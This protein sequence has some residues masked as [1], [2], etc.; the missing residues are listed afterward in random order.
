MTRPLY[1]FQGYARTPMVAP[2]PLG[3]TIESMA[4]DTTMR[5]WR[6]QRFG[7]R[8]VRH[9][10]DPLVEPL[11]SGIRVLAHAGPDGAEFLDAD[12]E[13]QSWPEI[14]ARLATVLQAERAVLDGYLTLESHDPGVG[15][16]PVPDLHPR[17]RDI[18]RRLFWVGDDR[19][20]RE[21]EAL[22]ETERPRPV[23][24]GEKAVFVAVDLLALDGEQLL[25]VPLLERKRL[26]DAVVGDDPLIRRGVHVRPPIGTWLATWKSLGF[27]AIAYKGANS[28]YRPGAPN[29]DWATAPILIR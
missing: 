3:C 26:L 4:V 23:E 14:A 13:T 25:D 29:D 10:D 12:G 18:G 27:R 2:A 8:N 11:W 5:A 19:R 28:R 22:R 9:I 6:P 7:R 20:Q 24:P 15:A 1:S 21:V 17:A 16:F